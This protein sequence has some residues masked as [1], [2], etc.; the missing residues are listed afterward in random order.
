MIL[1]VFADFFFKFEEEEV[2]ISAIISPLIARR[3][4]PFVNFLELDC[5]NKFV[6]DVKKH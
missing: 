5:L 2:A 6:E 3:V 1:D 4:F